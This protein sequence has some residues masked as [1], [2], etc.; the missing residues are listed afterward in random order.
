MSLLTP[1]TGLL[2]WMT[3][4]FGIV[5]FILAKYGFPII[6]RAIE[7]RNQYIN[8]SLE[9]AREA[10]TRLAALHSESEALLEQARKERNLLLQ[11]AQEM[12]KKIISEARETAEAEAR[13]QIE[14]ATIEIEETKKRA[15]GEIRGQIAEISVAI[16]GKVLGSK[17]ESSEQQNRL[18][19]R[20]LD[21]ELIPKN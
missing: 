20:L 13:L 9:A 8:D 5:F 3:L 12:K 17:L 11:E 19:D 10:E 6:N 15:L 21:D 7:K 16:A 14:K 18:I 2:F 4:S 1:D